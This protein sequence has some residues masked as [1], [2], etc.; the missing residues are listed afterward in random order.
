VGW[1]G[2]VSAPLVH[3]SIEQ[4]RRAAHASR[5]N[6]NVVVANRLFLLSG[7]PIANS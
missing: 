2:N 6:A 3:G 1:F 5:P 7:W 4:E